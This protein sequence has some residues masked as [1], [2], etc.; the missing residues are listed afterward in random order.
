M[1]E[2]DKAQA[3][4]RAAATM[5]MGHAFALD[6]VQ[7]S[8]NAG[9]AASAALRRLEAD[10]AGLCPKLAAQGA[11]V[12]EG[13]RAEPRR[14]AEFLRNAFQGLDL[15][16]ALAGEGDEAALD[17][18]LR[19]GVS[20]FDLRMAI[21]AYASALASVEAAEA[22]GPRPM[23]QRAA[24][25]DGERR[26]AGAR[27][28]GVASVVVHPGA[29]ALDPR[30]DLANHSPDGFEWGYGGSG[31]SQL[32]LA[33]CADALGDDERALAAYQRFKFRVVG[34]LP[35]AWSL[36]ASDVRTIVADLEAPRHA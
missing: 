31:P 12:V 28:G 13:C 29:A 9:L 8:V 33:L 25:G 2:H 11:R 6:L 5:A 18:M 34:K 7:A 1:D 10:T 3:P 35:A 36:S 16:L 19:S 27:V 17:A 4:A 22:N 32:A 15:H 30:F 24:D 14:A 26:Y 23:L 20:A 21:N